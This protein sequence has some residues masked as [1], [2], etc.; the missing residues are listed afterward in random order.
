MG[1]AK[2]KKEAPTEDE[3]V[4]SLT[5]ELET[6]TDRDD[7]HGPI[8]VTVDDDDE[9]DIDV[10]G[11]VP[12]RDE[13]KKNRWREHTE[14]RVAAETRASELERQLA[15]ERG[16]AQAFY[17][18]Q[19]Q[20]PQQQQQVDPFAQQ[21]QAILQEID[22][23]RKDFVNMDTAKMSSEDVE[24]YHKRWRDL[25]TAHKTI[26][27][28]REIQRATPQ[29]QPNTMAQAAETHVRVNYPELA[30]NAVA[31]QYTNGL[32][33]QAQAERTRQTGRQEPPT[34]QMLDAALKQT[35]RAL[36]LGPKDPPTAAVKARF[37]GMPA[38]QSGAQ[39]NGKKTVQLG[40][41][42]RSMARTRW[43]KLDPDAAYKRF[44]KEMAEDDDA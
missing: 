40:K 14:A 35:R 23:L 29:Q 1:A 7:V 33:I 10:P 36:S 12:T 34:M 22:H 24:R 28:R 17:E 6:A 19:R 27:T 21:E 25:D 32:L 43:P 44:A 26:I 38:T 5:S 4:D 3:V 30:E 42:E 31:L 15:E 41:A 8:E 13:K 39:P 9:P 11:E 16:R 18:A 20:Q 37:S 2:Q